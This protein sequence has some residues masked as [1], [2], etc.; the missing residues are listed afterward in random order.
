MISVVSMNSLYAHGGVD[1]QGNKC[2]LTVGTYK[3]LFT[4]Y[5]PKT[6]GEEFCDD[7]PL[8]G[9]TIIVLDFIDPILRSMMVDYRVFHDVNDV[10]ITATLED[11]A[12]I[13]DLDD[14]TIFYLPPKQYPTG[15]FMVNNDFKNGQYIGVLT[16]TNIESGNVITSVFPFT[17]GIQQVNNWLIILVLTLFLVVMFFFFKQCRTD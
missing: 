3:M 12:D 4:G 11:V 6:S 10:G 9:Q 17:V 13:A 2:F 16:V 7:I 5:Q 15:T 8:A 14:A 1:I